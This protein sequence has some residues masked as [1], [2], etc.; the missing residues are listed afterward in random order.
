MQLTLFDNT[1]NKDIIECVIQRLNAFDDVR[2]ITKRRVIRD[3]VRE[4]RPNLLFLE[5][6][7]LTNKIYEEWEM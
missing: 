2:E 6:I 7:R 3:V 5:S 4:L 1:S